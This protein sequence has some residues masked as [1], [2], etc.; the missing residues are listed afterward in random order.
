MV[1]WRTAYLNK[2]HIGST[3]VQMDST[4]CMIQA[5][6]EARRDCQFSLNRTS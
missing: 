2:I 5:R 4:I 6:K 1:L 3:L